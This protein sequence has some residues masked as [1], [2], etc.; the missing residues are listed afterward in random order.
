MK[1]I[2]CILVVSLLAAFVGGCN[3]APAPL[4]QVTILS[5]DMLPAYSIPDV[6]MIPPTGTPISSPGIIPSAT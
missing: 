6:T 4:P 5:T 2:L 1:R 3:V